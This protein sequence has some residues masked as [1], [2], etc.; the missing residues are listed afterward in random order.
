MEARSEVAVEKFLSGYNCAQS[1]LY[2]YCDDFQFDQ[3]TAL[4]LA[5]GLG[6][7]MGR[8]EE[9]ITAGRKAVAM[10][11][12]SR[13]AILGID[14]LIT[15]VQIYAVVGEDESSL[16]LIGNILSVPGIYTFRYF[17]MHP[18]FDTIRDEPGYRK[19]RE[20]CARTPG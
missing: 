5:C 8:K 2:S 12:V 6:A 3:N 4:K 13:D 17:E 20:E 1:V 15:L 10:Y 16:E 9:A 18:S 14:R 19:I 7:G 11:P